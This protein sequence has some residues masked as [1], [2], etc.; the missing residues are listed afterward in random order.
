MNRTLHRFRYSHILGGDVRIKKSFGATSID[1]FMARLNAARASRGGSPVQW[2]GFGAEMLIPVLE[3]FVEFRGTIPEADRRY[4]LRDAVYKAATETDF[5]RKALGKNLQDAEDRYLRKPQQK[6]IVATSWTASPDLEMRRLSVRGATVSFA[7]RHAN[8][9]RE[10]IRDVLD[11]VTP[12]PLPEMLQ[13]QARVTARTPSGALEI[14]L[15]C[16]DYARGVWNF[17][18]N[19]R[20]AY[21]LFSSGLQTP[22]N[23]ILPGPIHTVH[24]LRGKLATETV[25]YELYRIDHVQLFSEKALLSKIEVTAQKVRGRLSRSAYGRDIEHAFVRYTRALDAMDHAVAFAR[26]WATIEYLA[27]TSDHDNLIRRIAF[28]TDEKERSFVEI[29]MRHLRDVRNGVVHVDASRERADVREGIEAYLYQLKIFAE[30]LLLFHVRNS[31]KYE[32]R[33]AAA[34][35]L[36]TPTDPEELKRVIKLYRSMLRH[37]S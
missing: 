25:W 8:L 2:H 6:F 21:R 14:G 34:R 35:F 1:E 22:M 4:L 17:L 5:D 27:D 32:T 12:L 3:S 36:D 31:H 28:L 37:R 18:I 13:V 16:L 9:D 10:P 24:T 19:R 7:Q 26:L 20:T 23:K 33:A 30:W 11:R 29:M 15:H